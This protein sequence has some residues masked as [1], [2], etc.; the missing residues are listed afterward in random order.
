MRVVRTGKQWKEYY[1]Y[2]GNKTV[3]ELEDAAYYVEKFELK[4]GKS[5]RCVRLEEVIL[6]K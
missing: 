4:F 6:A 1:K 5:F 2:A 3:Q